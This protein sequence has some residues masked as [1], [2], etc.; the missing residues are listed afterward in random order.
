MPRTKQALKKRAKPH[1]EATLK[2]R[3]RKNLLKSKRRRARS[4]PKRRQG[5]GKGIKQ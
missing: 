4:R 3:S 1:R 2:L 5:T